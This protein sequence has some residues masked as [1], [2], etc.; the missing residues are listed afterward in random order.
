M[1]RARRNTLFHFIF[2]CYLP[3]WGD[4]DDSKRVRKSEK[5]VKDQIRWQSLGDE[6]NTR[7]VSLIRKLNL[8]WKLIY[9]W[10]S[11]AHAHKDATIIFHRNIRFE[12]SKLTTTQFVCSK[13]H[14]AEGK[15]K[16]EILS[17][18]GTIYLPAVFLD[19]LQ[20]ETS[21]FPSF[22]FS[23]FLR[24]DD[25]V[26][27]VLIF[28]FEYFSSS[29]SSA[30]RWMTFCRP[31]FYANSMTWRDDDKNNRGRHIVDGEE[32]NKNRYF[33][34]SYF[35]FVFSYS[36]YFDEL[37]ELSEENE[38]KMKTKAKFLLDK[39]K[40]V[41]WR[42]ALARIQFV[43]VSNGMQ[44]IDFNENSLE[45]NGKKGCFLRLFSSSHQNKN[46][47]SWFLFSSTLC[48]VLGTL[49][50]CCFFFLRLWR[51]LLC[52]HQMRKEKRMFSV[53]S[54]SWRRPIE[55]NVVDHQAAH[56]YSLR[57]SK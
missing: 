4:T 49:C 47:F 51:R 20:I 2:F 31:N 32:T 35:P 16:R 24:W 30:L 39:L 42:K 10:V 5:S 13:E 12:A 6:N 28:F 56:S 19:K 8:R 43:C 33:N 7:C 26:H 41:D 36:F 37:F 3:A 55:A 15:N 40:L 29:S 23:L 48:S 34:S 22:L 46:S 25:R 17:S 14:K 54:L 9:G 53:R 44:W 18:M 38:E 21:K 52:C 27:Y 45:S 1:T 11:L 57:T 50:C